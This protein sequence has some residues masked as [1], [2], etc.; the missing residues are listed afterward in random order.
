[1]KAVIPAYARSPFHFARQGALAE[2]RPDILA[3]QMRT[4]ATIKI[5]DRT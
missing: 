3:A 2:V 5:Q 4:P 1:M